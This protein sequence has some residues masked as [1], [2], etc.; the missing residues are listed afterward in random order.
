MMRYCVLAFFI[1]IVQ[2][3]FSQ[4]KFQ[5]AP[6][7]LQ[8][9]SAFFSDASSIKI[10]FNQ[11]GTEVRYTLDGRDPKE[12]DRL[13]TGPVTIRNNTLFKARAFGRDFLPSDVVTA[14]FVKVGLPI[15]SAK[16]SKPNESYASSK[17]DL[18][19]DNIGGIV[20]YRS[21]TWVGFDSDTVTVDIELSRKEKI[22]NILVDLLQDENSWIFM[23]TRLTA[24]YYDDNKKNYLPLAE[25]TFKHDEPGSKTCRVVELKSSTAFKAGRLRL[26]FLTLKTI[27]AWHAGKGQHG[28]LFID[29]IKVY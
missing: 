2:N 1:S 20:N 17:P 22:K 3:G 6:P 21:G 15:R 29:E 12:S 26:V 4:E 28:W 8:Y 5:L 14:T 10:I 9:Q 23:P 25:Q 19:I 27:P 7:M 24:Y 13:Y 16:F 18:L 11:P